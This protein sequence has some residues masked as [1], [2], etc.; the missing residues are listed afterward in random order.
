[1][2]GDPSSRGDTGRVRGYAATVPARLLLLVDRD[3]LRRK[4]AAAA[5]RSSG[6]DVRVDEQS[7]SASTRPLGPFDVPEVWVVEERALDALLARLPS[8]AGARQG[9]AIVV[10]GADP[11]SAAAAFGKG[12]AGFVLETELV[13]I[14]DVVARSVE[15]VSSLRAVRDRVLATLPDRVEA[16]VRD[17]LRA[18][19]DAASLEAARREAHA[20]RGVVGSVGLDAVAQPAGE[21]ELELTEAAPSWSA[22]ELAVERLRHAVAESC[23]P[24]GPTLR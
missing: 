20:L 24:S 16:L 2:D 9:R 18:R 10:V 22:V 21:I 19:T 15:L 1:M 4:V 17:A 12:A 13:R 3:P 14:A 11:A 8:D 7:A 5:L 23:A 6:W